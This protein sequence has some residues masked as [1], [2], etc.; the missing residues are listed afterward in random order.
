MYLQAHE[1]VLVD[2]FEETFADEYGEGVWNE[3]SETVS[4]DLSRNVVALASFY[5]NLIMR[6]YLLLHIC[7]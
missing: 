2:T 1:L 4:Y 6:C 5:G 3:L 7:I